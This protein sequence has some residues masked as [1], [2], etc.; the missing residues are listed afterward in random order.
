M[1]N[2][3]VSGT[4]ILGFHPGIGSGDNLL[5]YVTQAYQSVV[6][7][8]ERDVEFEDAKLSDKIKAMRYRMKLRDNEDS[9]LTFIGLEELN[10]N[11]F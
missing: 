6:L 4:N 2:R 5:A 1:T 8:Y 9:N 7:V 10:Q 11:S 3:L